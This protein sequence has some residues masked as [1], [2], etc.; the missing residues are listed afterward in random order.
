MLRNKKGFTLIEM[1]GVLAVISILASMVAPK[2]FDVIADSKATHVAGTANTVSAA[3]ANWYRDI[4]GLDTL[5]AA[6]TLSGT[7]TTAA[8]L[9]T[10]L[11][12]NGGTTTTT[13][14]WANWRGPYIN[15]MPTPA[16][17]SSLTIN[18]IQGSGTLVATNGAGW[19]FNADGTA[20]TSTS[21]MVVYMVLASVDQSAFNRINSIIDSGLS[22]SST[23]NDT[24][25]RAKYD[26]SGDNVYVYI[27][28]S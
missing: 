20:D 4:G 13:G 1:I 10:Q 19:D 23:T 3:T 7:T 22:A 24:Y 18:V 11:I 5:A 9:G 2:I 26:A 27:I 14:L 16:V 25:G 6:G 17:G 12:A 28:H 8:N 15:G 21:N